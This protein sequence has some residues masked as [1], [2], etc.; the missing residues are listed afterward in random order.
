MIDS[1]AFTSL[2][3]YNIYVTADNNVNLISRL[4][5][6]RANTKLINLHR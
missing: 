6:P 4:I 5:Y 2:I 1:R 3:I